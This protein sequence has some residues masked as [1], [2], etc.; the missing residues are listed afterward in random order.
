MIQT[1]FNGAINKFRS[2]N[3]KYY[4]NE[5]LAMSRHVSIHHNKMELLKEI[6][7]IFYQLK[8]HFYFKIMFQNNIGGKQF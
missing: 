2:D 6:M 1:Q 5:S 7:D 3:V 8:E 4:L